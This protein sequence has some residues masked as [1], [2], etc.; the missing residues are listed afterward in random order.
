MEAVLKLQQ[1]L[2]E[3]YYRQFIL[4]V[5]EDKLDFSP[6]VNQIIYRDKEYIELDIELIRRKV[7][8]IIADIK[9][10]YLNA[11]SEV[12]VKLSN[13]SNNIEKLNYLNYTTQLF[14]IPSNQ[15]KKDFYIDDEGSRYYSKFDL[16][17]VV[18]SFED[19]YKESIENIKVKKYKYDYINFDFF[20]SRTKI[21][22]FLP[23]SLF[24]IVNSFI[25]ILE[26]KV[27]EIQEDIEITVTTESKLK[28]IGKPSQ[29]G[30]IIGQLA[31]L[32]YINTPIRP[33][34]EINYTLFAKE[35]LTTFHANTTESTLTKYLNIDTEK[36][37]E[38]ERN[39]KKAKFN[40][41]H[42]IEVS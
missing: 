3:N 1:A 10:L 21:I 36:S 33:N 16:G 41:P 20:V 26:K 37:Q 32:E 30:Y 8:H 31:Q 5:E 17:D 38:T 28:W 22:S 6:N 35:V 42:I 4:S 39:F 12:L 15:I 19:L 27:L 40:I 34:G 29:L 24:S 18:I 23:I 25:N 7:K 14:N 9:P 13:L 2:T 11:L